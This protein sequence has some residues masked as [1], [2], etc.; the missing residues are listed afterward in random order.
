MHPVAKSSEPK[1]AGKSGDSKSPKKEDPNVKK[2]AIKQK[3]AETGS[4]ADLLLPAA[5]AF[6]GIGFAVLGLVRMRRQ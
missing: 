2:S 4:Y 6:F 5:L 1:T 3:L